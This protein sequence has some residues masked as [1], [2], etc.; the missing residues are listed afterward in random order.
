MRGVW[1]N[2][3]WAVVVVCAAP[4][5]ASDPHSHPAF[6][7]GLEQAESDALKVSIPLRAAEADADAAEAQGDAQ[8]TALFPRLT[9]QGQAQYQR[10][11]PVMAVGFGPPIE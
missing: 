1:W 5:V 2:L 10:I 7:L 8:Y 4:A 9:L 6:A 3:I 11:V